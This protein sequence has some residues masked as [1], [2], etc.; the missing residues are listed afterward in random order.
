MIQD[1]LIAKIC[2]YGFSID[3]VTLFYLYLKRRKQNLRI[4]YTH[5]V[6]AIL[7]PG[8]PKVQFFGHFYSTTDL[9][10][11]AHDNFIRAAENTIERLISTLE[12]DS[13]AA[14]DQFKTNEMTVNPDKFETIF[15]K[16]SCR[17]KDSYALNIS[18]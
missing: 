18:N 3:V 4:I 1:L 12:Q 10:N 16:K 14:I 9:I 15:V 6:F 7:L 17:I 8:V 13:Q 11:F 5:S 2:A